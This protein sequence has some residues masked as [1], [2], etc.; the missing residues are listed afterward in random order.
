[1]KPVTVGVVII[2][3]LWGLVGYLGYST[4]TQSVEDAKHIRLEKSESRN[5]QLAGV[6]PPKHFY[7]DLKDVETGVTDVQVY[8][9][10]HCNSWKQTAVVG[11]MYRIVV[12]TYR[13]DR[14]NT[15]KV[16]YNNLYNVFCVDM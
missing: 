3:L 11:K 9:S 4:Y 13:D 14:D 15:L 8:V 2:I 10:K 7:V 16:K 5:F 6:R 1:M 12:E